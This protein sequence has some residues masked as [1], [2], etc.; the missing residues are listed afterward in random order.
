MSMFLVE[1]NELNEE[2][3][4]MC[5]KLIKKILKKV[6]DLITLEQATQ[7]TSQVRTMTQKF[8]ERAET[9]SLLVEYEGYLEDVKN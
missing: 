6:E 5:E 1:C 8:S 7:V 4:V 3:I 9:S 2:L